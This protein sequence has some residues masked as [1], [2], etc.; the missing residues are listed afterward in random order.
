VQR[1]STAEYAGGGIFIQNISEGSIGGVPDLWHTI[2]RVVFAVSEVKTTIRAGT[3]ITSNV[4]GMRRSNTE[5][6][7][8]GGLYLVRGQFRQNLALDVEIELFTQQVY[9]NSARSGATKVITGE[10]KTIRTDEIDL[11]DVPARIDHGDAEVKQHLG[12]GLLTPGTT[13]RYKS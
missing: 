13:F 8:G 5:H 6:A 2:L 11:V 10:D 4:A 3:R 9:G 7:K 12:A 1:N